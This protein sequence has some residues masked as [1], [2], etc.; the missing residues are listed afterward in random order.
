MLRLRHDTVYFNPP[1]HV[2]MLV[3]TRQSDGIVLK[4]V[5]RQSTEVANVRLAFR[6]RLVSVKPPQIAELTSTPAGTMATGFPLLVE[7]TL[8]NLPDA[9]KTVSNLTAGAFQFI[10]GESYIVAVVS[11]AVCEFNVIAD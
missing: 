6:Q 2:Q 9:Y 1:L 10:S 3:I 5:P 4:V 8:T 7:L 11:E